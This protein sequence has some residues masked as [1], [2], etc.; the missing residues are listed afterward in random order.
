MILSTL[1][2]V[3]LA[4]KAD[5]DGADNNYGNYQKFAEQFRKHQKIDAKATEDVFYFFTLHDYNHDGFLDG[6]ELRNAFIGFEYNADKD[7]VVDIPIKDLEEFIDH[8][9]AEDDKDNNGKIS[10]EEYLESQYY[11]HKI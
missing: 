4:N 3:V 8:T 11:H 10:W 2:A 7:Q 5:W 9:L 1:L 6:H